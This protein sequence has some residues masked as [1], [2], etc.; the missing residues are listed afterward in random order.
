MANFEIF[1]SLTYCDMDAAIKKARAILAEYGYNPDEFSED[2]LLREA[3]EQTAY[4][5]EY[6]Q[7]TLDHILDGQVV[8]FA[9][10]GRW[11]GRMDGGRMGGVNLNE[12]L[13]SYSRGE[14]R[15]YVEDE[16]LKADEAHHDGENHYVYRLLPDSISDCR[17][18]LFEAAFR[19]YDFKKAIQY[20]KPLGKTVENWTTLS[21]FGS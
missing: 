13:R 8:V 19:A 18:N 1:S 15:V 5:Y 20:T 12:C 17:R 4:E 11:N 14:L 10:L 21:Q 9:D 16:E 7:E 6:A 2:E 3:E